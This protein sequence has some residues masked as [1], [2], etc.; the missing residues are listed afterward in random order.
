MKNS[1][2]EY[3]QRSNTVKVTPIQCS[4]Q[5]GFDLI[6]EENN[7]ENWSA[8]LLRSNEI[9]ISI[10]EL[11]RV[12]QTLFHNISGNSM[13]LY[14]SEFSILHIPFPPVLYSCLPFVRECNR[15]ILHSRTRS[16][17]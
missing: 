15:C 3:K 2:S 13:L 12:S 6:H 16:I 5:T 8:A 11:P 7:R 4:K 10:D 14:S 1:L 17:L 9:G